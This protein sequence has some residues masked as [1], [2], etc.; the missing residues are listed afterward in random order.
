MSS[1]RHHY[2]PYGGKKDRS[3]Q[4]QRRVD[5]PYEEDDSQAGSSS[6]KPPRHTKK[7][8]SDEFQWDLLEPTTK[9]TSKSRYTSS[10]NQKKRI[11]NRLE[12]ANG[13][14]SLLCKTNVWTE[15]P[16]LEQLLYLST[17]RA[18]M[19]NGWSDW[20]NYDLQSLHADNRRVSHLDYGVSSGAQVYAIKR[21][22]MRAWDLDLKR[23]VQYP[24]SL[25][26]LVGVTLRHHRITGHTL[27][28]VV[29]EHIINRQAWQAMQNA[30]G[31]LEVS[32]PLHP[33]SGKAGIP[34]VCV[35][36]NSIDHRLAWQAL[37]V[38]NPFTRMLEYLLRD[39]RI[40][41]LRVVTA[42]TIAAVPQIRWS[43]YEPQE[44]WNALI[45]HF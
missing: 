14:L 10:T 15:S 13:E 1:H 40:D 39:E 34:E 19:I 43:P 30:L 41:G 17:D 35:R 5:R 3:E 45:A 11:F 33:G 16:E 31:L 6:S 36:I 29:F 12:D 24:Y 7:G 37:H 28:H 4:K 26:N 20:H 44:Y 21:A 2:S 22:T 42:Y 23:E 27:K 9:K 25:S 8:A 32:L 38:N 18:Q